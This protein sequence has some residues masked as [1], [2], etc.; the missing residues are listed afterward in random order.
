LEYLQAGAYTAIML[1]VLGVPQMLSSYFDLKARRQDEERRREER[2]QDDERRR[3]EHRMEQE[4][5]QRDQ[6]MAE[7]RHQELMTLLVATINNGNNQGNGQVELIRTLQQTIEDLR[8][9]NAQL[10]QQNGNGSSSA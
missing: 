4:I 2:R 10:R 8:A 3:D 1:A 7:R 5:R 6:E 9:E